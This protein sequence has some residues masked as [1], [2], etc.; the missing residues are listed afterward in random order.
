MKGGNGGGDVPRHW[1]F[2]IMW[3]RK[4]N[5]INKDNTRRRRVI[6]NKR[7]GVEHVHGGG[8][9]PHPCHACYLGRTHILY[10][11]HKF[12]LSKH[13]KDGFYDF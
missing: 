7:G 6:R 12:K 3:K 13:K 8:D 5:N 2:L 11:K 9:A 4:C 10:N 1:W